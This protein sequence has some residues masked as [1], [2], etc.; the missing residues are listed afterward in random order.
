MFPLFGGSFGKWFQRNVLDSNNK[1]LTSLLP[2]S[3]SSSLTAQQFSDTTTVVITHNRNATMSVEIIDL[4]G[5]HIAGHIHQ[6]NNSI[7]ITFNV[8][9]SGTVY[10]G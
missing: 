5:N 1:I 10:F 3:Q 8:P 7:T 2:P 6:T 4:N 9:T